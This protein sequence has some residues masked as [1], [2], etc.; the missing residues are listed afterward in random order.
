MPDMLC[1]WQDM[2]ISFRVINKK[3]IDSEVSY[4]LFPLPNEAANIPWWASVFLY[5]SLFVALYHSTFQSHPLANKQVY[6]SEAVFNRCT[7]L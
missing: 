2:E 1:E 4:Q 6:N 3:G 7:K 5:L